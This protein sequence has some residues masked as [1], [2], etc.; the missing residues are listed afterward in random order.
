MGDIGLMG[1]PAKKD[2]KATEGFRIFLGGKIGEDPALAQ[3][4]ERGVPADDLEGKLR[5]ILIEHFGA[6]PKAPAGAA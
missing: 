2:G 6:K 1:A 5:S 3:E 4:M